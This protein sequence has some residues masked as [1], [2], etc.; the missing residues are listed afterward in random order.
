MSS[1]RDHGGHRAHY[2]LSFAKAC[3]IKGTD[4]SLK[5]FL[6]PNKDIKFLVL[7]ERYPQ[8]SVMGIGMETQKDSQSFGQTT[9]FTTLPGLKYNS[10][11]KFGS[12]FAVQNTMDVY[13]QYAQKFV[14][15][16]G[17]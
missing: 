11:K 13:A 12:S 6:Y 4:W 3:Q 14:R 16:R 15:H 10:S 8:Y 5:T 9:S 17:D 7:S 2:P 1:S